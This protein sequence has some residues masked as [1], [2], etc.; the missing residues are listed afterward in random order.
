MTAN[1]IVHDRD[2]NTVTARGHV[3]VDQGGRI[4]LAD[5]LSYNLKQDVIIATGNVS[6]TETT[7]EVIF[8]DYI[9]LTG[10]MK[11]ST[12]RGIRV[13][14]IDDFTPGGQ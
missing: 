11:E 9:E 10:D 2:L 7:G 13:L 8:A 3:E 6:L 14:L 4:L 5:T 1:Q 12:A